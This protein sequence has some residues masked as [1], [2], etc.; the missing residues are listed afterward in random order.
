MSFVNSFFKKISY[1]GLSKA[2]KNV[3]FLYL[4]TRYR[5]ISLMQVI[6]I[7]YRNKNVLR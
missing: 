4:K 3:F 7:G 5:V 2:L 6:N 1:R